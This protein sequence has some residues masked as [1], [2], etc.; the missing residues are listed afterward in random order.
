MQG[1]LRETGDGF[2]ISEKDLQLR[3][4]GEAL[5]TIQ[6]GRMFTRLADLAEHADLI[7]QARDLAHTEEKLETRLKTEPFTTLFNIFQKA[8]ATELIRS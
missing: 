4:P 1:E 7:P 8:E 6:A 3:G 2:I 5:G